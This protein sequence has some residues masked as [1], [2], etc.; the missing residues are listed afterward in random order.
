MSKASELI[1]K[2]RVGL[3][4]SHPFFGSLCLKL[5]M[6]EDTTIWP[7]TAKTNGTYIKYHPDYVKSLTLEEV[8]ALLVHEIIHVSNCHH[9]RLQNRDPLKGNIAMDYATNPFVKDCGFPVPN[10]WLYKKEWAGDAWEAIYNRLPDPPKGGGG[11]GKGG[12]GQ[13]DQG[14]GDQMF[15]EVEQAT[16]PDGSPLS[17][18]QR[19]MAEQEM[20]IAVTQAAQQAKAMGNLPAAL[21]RLVD[22]ILEPKIDWKEVLRNFVNKA[23]KNDYTWSRPNRRFIGQ[24]LYLPSLF[25]MELG[26]LVLCVDTSGS[27]STKELNEFA[28]ELNGILEEFDA[29]L[30]VLYCDAEVNHVETFRKE[31]LPLHLKPVGGGGTDFRP[32][33][34][35]IKKQGQDPVCM[36]YFTDAY[37]TFP[38][39]APDYPV[40]WIINNDEK[41]NVPFGQVI[42]L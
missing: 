22:E 10:G 39:D 32:C 1:K 29:E 41:H 30:T 19:A 34:N 20:K 38:K 11:K 2:A 33:F 37:G 42:R 25:S 17:E 21:E 36:L 7:P 16:N 4:L 31:D 13:N 26:E 23:A 15:D 14:Q 40:L 27:I 12:E 6:I 9:L 8:K 5:Q 28:A 18:A 3:I 35:W 24:G